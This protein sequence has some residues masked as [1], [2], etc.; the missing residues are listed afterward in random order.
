MKGDDSLE[1]Y[2]QGDVLLKRVAPASV[3][4]RKEPGLVL[5]TG[6]ATG[7]DHTAS[8]EGAVIVSRDRQR[9]LCAPKGAEVTHPQHLSL[10]LPPGTYRIDRVRECDH[11]GEQVDAERAKDLAKAWRDS[12]AAIEPPP[13]PPAQSVRRRRHGEAGKD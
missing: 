3:G 9:Y 7:H 2:Q 5:A 8:G 6:A 4:G 1:L 10:R 13:R 12:L 11:F